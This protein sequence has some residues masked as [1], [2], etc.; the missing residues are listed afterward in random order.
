MHKDASICDGRHTARPVVE[1][2]AVHVIRGAFEGPQLHAQ[3]GVHRFHDEFVTEAMSDDHFSTCDHGSGESGAE[4]SIPNGLRL[5]EIFASRYL[6]DTV[7]PRAEQLR[8]VRC[9]E[10]TGGEPEKEE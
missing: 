6:H 4:F 1:T 5:D 7:T 3:R 9:V 8:P 10:D 2:E